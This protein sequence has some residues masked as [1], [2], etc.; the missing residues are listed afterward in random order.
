ML[1]LREYRKKR[2]LTLRELAKRSR[3]HF[4]NLA[5]IESGQLDPRLSTVVKIANALRVSM[6]DFVR[7]SKTG[8]RKSK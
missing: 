6:T 1:R 2:G 4:V 7:V 3:V 5:R 8:R